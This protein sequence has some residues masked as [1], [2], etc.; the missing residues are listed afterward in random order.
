MQRRERT[1]RKRRGIKKQMYK[2]DVI[3]SLQGCDAM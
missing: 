1:K 2:E 3:Y